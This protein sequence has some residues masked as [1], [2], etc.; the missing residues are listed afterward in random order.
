MGQ[1]HTTSHVDVAPEQAFE[2]GAQA[3]RMP[4][5]NASIVEVKD[6]GGPLDTA[7]AGY[8]AV[9]KL[10]G[11]KLEGHWAVTRVEK[12]LF[13]ELRGTA[14]GGGT[15]T[16]ITRYAP[17]AGGTDITIELDYELPGGFI[18]GLA[19]KLF[20]ERAIERDL[21]HSSE[22]FKAIVEAEAPVHA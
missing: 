3:E 6:V 16:W 18:G 22:N 8:T 12:P 11:R 10:G 2:F 13:A 5:W 15:A 21:R 1:V 20:V 17:A 7:G 4:E 14:P 9:M 19:D